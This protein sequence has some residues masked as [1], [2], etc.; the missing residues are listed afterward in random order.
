[1]T[2]D[3]AHGRMIL[4]RG[5]RFAD[6]FEADASGM[7]VRSVGGSFRQFEVSEVAASTRPPRPAYRS[8]TACW[9]WT[10]SLMLG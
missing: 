5:A 10:A 8:A 9:P 7:R 6:P 3:Y 1:M 2:L 4:E